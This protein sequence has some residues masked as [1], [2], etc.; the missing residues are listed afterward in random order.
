MGGWVGGT[1]LLSKLLDEDEG[2]NEDVSIGHVLPH[3]LQGGGVTE[4]LEEVAVWGGVGGWV[5]GWVGG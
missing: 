3:F 2:A 1:Y 4:F 5:G